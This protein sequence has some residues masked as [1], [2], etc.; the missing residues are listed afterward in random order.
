MLLLS[1]LALGAPPA[2]L[3]VSFAPG[4]LLFPYYAGAAYAMQEA[5]LIHSA[6]P[7]GGSSAGSIIAAAIACDV[8]EETVQVGLSSLVADLRAGVGLRVAV[9][10]QLRQLLPDD[11]V[12]RVSGRLTV[13]YQRIL[14][15]PKSCFVTEWED[16]EDL[17]DTICASCNWPFFFSRWPLV[18]VRNTL[19]T[20][21]FFAVPRSR[22]GCPPLNA[23]RTVNVLCLPSVATEFADEELI[24]PGRGAIPPI[25]VDQGRW[26][27]WALEA[28]EDEDLANIYA[29]GRQHAVSWMTQYTSE[30]TLKGTLMGAPSSSATSS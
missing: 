25:P 29:L 11:A 2:Q 10:E 16:K 14:P 19:A 8:P 26:F 12:E 1:V 28:A 21:G 30:G 4:G 5:G 15:W 3:G 24:Q 22:F 7:V 27:K 6:T 18:W 17:V 23:D 20:D 9:R 13:C